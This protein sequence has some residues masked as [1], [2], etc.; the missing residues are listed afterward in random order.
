MEFTVVPNRSMTAFE[1][2]DLAAWISAEP[3]SMRD[4][5]IV[6]Q[7]PRND[8]LGVIGD[9]LAIALGSGGATGLTTAL[10]TWIRHR[11]SDLD[12][13]VTAPDGT[14]VTMRGK[15]LQALATEEVLPHIK[16]ISDALAQSSPAEPSSRDH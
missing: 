8:Q 14:V 11:T 10:V 13:T 7:A 15:R 9:G 12:L 5:R 1:L 2:R 4:V 16:S 6:E 3:G